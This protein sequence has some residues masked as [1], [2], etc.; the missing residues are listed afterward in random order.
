MS[1]A[2]Y[3]P[4][5]TAGWRIVNSLWMLTGFLSLGLLWFIGFWMVAIRRRTSALWYIA[6]VV[7]TALDVA[8]IVLVALSNADPD[9]SV[10]DTLGSTILGII[11][12]GVP[13]AAFTMNVSWLRWLWQDQLARGG[14]GWTAAPAGFAPSPWT[15]GPGVGHVPEGAPVAWAPGQAGGQSG[16]LGGAAASYPAGQPA[17]NAAWGRSGQNPPGRH[18]GGAGAPVWGQPAP[19]GQFGQPGQPDQSSRATPTAW[20]SA[21]YP[22]SQQ[23]ARV[24]GAHRGSAHQGSPAPAPAAPADTGAVPVIGGPQLDLNAAS[25]AQLAALPG[26]SGPLAL[27]IVA[28]RDARGAYARV[29]DLVARGV[30]QPH[31]F[32]AFSTGLFAGPLAAPP[33]PGLDGEPAARR[34]DDGGEAGGGRRL[35]F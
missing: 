29:S 7:V 13:V 9:N 24:P 34:R 28:E 21:P 2:P 23:P 30:V 5:P 31:V 26:S 6:A 14:G 3:G 11:L 12:L 33:T 27:A 1:Y 35:E 4:R 8:V 10:L 18:A 32:L 17:G 16:Y 19:F 15:S 22:G 25:V 20:E